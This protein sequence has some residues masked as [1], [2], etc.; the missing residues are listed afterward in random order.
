[1]TAKLMM[2]MLVTAASKTARRLKG[3]IQ[4]PKVVASVI[5]FDGTE[6]A[7]GAIRNPTH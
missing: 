5:F 2:F 4:L 7:L 6:F 3:E 1:M